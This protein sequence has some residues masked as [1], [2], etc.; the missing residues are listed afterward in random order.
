VVP[1]LLK[2]VKYKYQYT[3]IL[4]I[5]NTHALKK[6]VSVT[7]Q[8]DGGKKVTVYSKAALRALKYFELT[9][10]SFS[11][12]VVAALILEDEIRKHYPFEWAEIEQAVPEK[13]TMGDHE[14]P[15]IT[16][17]NQ[18]VLMQAD[19]ETATRDGRLV[20]VYDPRVATML[21]YLAYTRPRFTRSKG[22]AELL[23]L[24]LQNRFPNL[25]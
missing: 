16:L 22:A 6:A 19:E 18:T 12:G 25:F 10:P 3:T 8:V 4:M 13:N 23:E 20:T 14:I 11:K 21:R 9:I 1:H 24:G 17:I 2:T 15:E 7:E 5:I